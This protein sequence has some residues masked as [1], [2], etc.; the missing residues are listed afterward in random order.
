MTRR[1]SRLRAALDP[2]KDQSYFLYRL[3]PEILSRVLFPL[4]ELTKAQ[5]RDIARR[6]GL[7]VAEKPESQDF[8]AG[9]DYSPLFAD[10]APESGEIVD[11]EGRVLGR[12]RGLPYYTIGQR[13]GLGIGAG[14]ARPGATPS[15]CMSS[16]STR[17]KIA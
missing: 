3:G 14:V 7:D 8:I 16:P 17:G 5:V 2:A 6:F 15:R 11:A 4:G 13:R 1:T 10:Q 12:H 9:G